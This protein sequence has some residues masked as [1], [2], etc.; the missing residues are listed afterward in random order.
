MDIQQQDIPRI[1]VL[2]KE[3]EKESG[4]GLPFDPVFASVRLMEFI[5][6]D[7]HCCLK[8][9]RGGV[10]QGFI[11]GQVSQYPF[12]QARQAH[13]VAWYCAKPYRRF[14]AVRLFKALEAWAKGKGAAFLFSGAHES[15]V[16]GFYEKAGMRLLDHN[17]VKAI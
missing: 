3:S 15:K 7:N 16:A 1:M 5:N 4:G 14:G 9:E 10:I 17:W 6:S 13:V 11:V 2:G 8:V 12:A